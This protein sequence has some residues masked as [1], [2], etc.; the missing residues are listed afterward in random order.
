[1]KLHHTYFYHPD[2]V[3]NNTAVIEH[4]ERQGNF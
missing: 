1:M 3:E 2:F 4:F